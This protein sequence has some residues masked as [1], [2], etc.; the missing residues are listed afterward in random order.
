M[1]AILMDLHFNCDIGWMQKSYP[2]HHQRQEIRRSLCGCHQQVRT[3]E[4]YIDKF[5]HFI[6]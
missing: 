1:N 6:K 3:G 2:P 4:V 5:T